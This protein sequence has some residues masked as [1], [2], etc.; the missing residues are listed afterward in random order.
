MLRHAKAAPHT[1]DDRGRPLTDRGRRQCAELARD[2]LAA[3]LGLPERT[4]SSPAVRARQTAE[5]VLEGLGRSSEAGLDLDGELYQAD[6]DDVIRRARLLDDT[7]TR[8]MVVGHN[9]T[10]ESLVMLLV[11]AD[12][13]NRAR[14]DEG[15]A[16]CALAVVE[17]PVDRWAE[18]V[19]GEGR[20]RSYFTPTGR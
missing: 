11:A 20:L 1:A 18:V 5:L 7:V 4:M 9:P 12:D 17:L 15:M 19:T 16:T 3:G 8:A 10:V 6:P 14:V 13:P 2:V